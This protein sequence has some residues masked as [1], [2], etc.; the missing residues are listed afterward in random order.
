MHPDAPSGCTALSRAHTISK[1]GA[2]GAVTEDG[3]VMALAPDLMNMA[4]ELPRHDARSVGVNEASTFFGFCN[5]H[6]SVFAPIDKPFAASREAAFLLHY[7]AMCFK[8]YKKRLSVGLHKAMAARMRGDSVRY[9]QDLGKQFYREGTQGTQ[10]GIRDLEVEKVALDEELR[11]KNWSACRYVAFHLDGAPPVVC[12]GAFAP[13]WDLAGLRLQ[14][15]SEPAPM[16]IA[17]L[18]LVGNGALG[19]CVIAWRGD[20]PACAKLAQSLIEVPL[21]AE[22]EVLVRLVFQMVENVFCAPTWWEALSQ[23][24]RGEVLQRVRDLQVY[25]SFARTGLPIPTGV[26][27]TG[28]TA[29]MGPNKGDQP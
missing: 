12:A 27:V 6:D 7:R 18:S 20:R 10:Q 5:A 15:I 28:V 8:L 1:S 14:D 24:Q 23:G 9:S 13:E 16:Q 21:S 25:A 29:E 11:A 19:V 4:Q 17:S 22:A 2:L 26:S 3:H